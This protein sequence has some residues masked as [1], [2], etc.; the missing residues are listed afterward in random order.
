[1]GNALFELAP[2]NFS[3]L[4]TVSFNSLSIIPLA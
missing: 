2:I 3:S 1:M 4:P